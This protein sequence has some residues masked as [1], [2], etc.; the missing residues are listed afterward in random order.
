MKSKLSTLCVG[1]TGGISL[2]V[3]CF[4][5]FCLYA[6]LLLVEFLDLKTTHLLWVL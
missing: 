2:S 4:L 3:F 1:R 6:V 5:F